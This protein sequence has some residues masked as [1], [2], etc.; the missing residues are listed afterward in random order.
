MV[1]CSEARMAQSPEA[2]L[3]RLTLRR[4]GASDRSA[5]Q[6]AARLTSRIRV[7]AEVAG[8]RGGLVHRCIA[9]QARCCRSTACGDDATFGRP[10]S[11]GRCSSAHELSPSA[12]LF[13]EPP[14]SMSKRGRAKGKVVVRLK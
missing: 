2:L 12:G 4:L 9:S 1:S 6:L 10:I 5:A 7:A 8:P 14:C 3:H 13:E 11:N